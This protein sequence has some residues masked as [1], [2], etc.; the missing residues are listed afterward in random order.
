[1]QRPRGRVERICVQ[2]RGPD[3]VHAGVYVRRDDVVD[4]EQLGAPRSAGA[5][6]VLPVRRDRLA[7][8]V[9]GAVCVP[10][11]VHPARARCGRCRLELAARI[12]QLVERLDARRIRV[13]RHRHAPLV[14]RIAH[15]TRRALLLLVQVRLEKRL[16]GAVQLLC[17]RLA[18]HVA[19]RRGISAAKAACHTLL[20]APNRRDQV[21]RAPRPHR[22]GSLEHLEQVRRTHVRARR[23]VP[24]VLQANTH[25]HILRGSEHG[26]DQPGAREQQRQ[27]PHRVVSRCAAP[28]RASPRRDLVT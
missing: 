27:R 21:R 18:R 25:R 4:P 1:M 19:Q 5:M 7:Q 14:H 22:M 12:V 17:V 16:D 28:C 2:D 11:V 23:T 26:K 20:R 3:R 24:G 10:R 8:L 13:L 6:P 15:G 9:R